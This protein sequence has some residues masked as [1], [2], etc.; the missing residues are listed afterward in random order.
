MFERS[1]LFG[2][3]WSFGGCFWRSQCLNLFSKWSGTS[4]TCKS[5]LPMVSP[6]PVSYR[7]PSYFSFQ[8]FLTPASAS[9]TPTS[10]PFLGWKPVS[11]PASMELQ[12]WP[13]LVSLLEKLNSWM[14]LVILVTFL[15]ITD[16]VRKRRPRNFPPGPQL[17]PFLGTIVDLRQPLHLEMQ[18]VRT[19]L[20]LIIFYLLS[21]FCHLTCKAKV[22]PEEQAVY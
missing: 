2:K 16:F 19:F 15:L 7:H 5:S 1:L 20:L 9:L 21:D 4:H 11:S 22:G 12:L 8:S 17:F 14:I 3:P 13:I 18:K 10:S 6:V